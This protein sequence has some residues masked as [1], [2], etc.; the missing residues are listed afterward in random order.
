MVDVGVF[1]GYW[2]EVCGERM[3]FGSALAWR[4]LGVVGEKECIVR[5]LTGSFRC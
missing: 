3:A 2:C 5:P 1:G 4:R